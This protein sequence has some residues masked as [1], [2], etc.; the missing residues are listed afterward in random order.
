MV[1]GQK[2]E[3]I[4]N[5]DGGNEHVWPRNNLL[6]R[7]LQGETTFEETIKPLIE[8]NDN[9]RLFGRRACYSNLFVIVA[10]KCRGQFANI[11]SFQSVH[12]G[13]VVDLTAVVNRSQWV[14]TELKSLVIFL[15]VLG[16]L[17]LCCYLFIGVSLTGFK[18]AL[19]ITLLGI[20]VYCVERAIQ[21]KVY[22]RHRRDFAG[23][24]LANAK[25]LDT[26]VAMVRNKE[27]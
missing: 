18:I 8:E 11:L 6:V 9:L 1:Q 21:Y 4:I 22:L 7:V 15:P 2:A 24:T 10:E 20:F 26:V 13:T 17:W 25:F 12:Q 14:W 19:A 5:S 3:F 27:E 16:V 23:K